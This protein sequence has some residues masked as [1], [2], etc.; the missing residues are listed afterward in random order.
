MGCQEGLEGSPFLP[1]PSSL[2]G[3]CSCS[4]SILAFQTQVGDLA[5]P[6]TPLSGLQEF[7]LHLSL[8]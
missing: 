8:L 3:A 4:F 2:T 5:Q 6:H 1:T 7:T